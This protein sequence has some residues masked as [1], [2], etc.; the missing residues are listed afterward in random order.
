MWDP[1]IVYH[2]GRYFLFAMYTSEAGGDFDS[3]W[4][5]VSDDGV[6]WEDVGA[7]I[8]GQPFYVAKMFVRKLG[9]RFV[10]NHGS[11][12]GEPGY[13]DT[14]YFWESDDLITWRLFDENRALHPDPRWYR[15]EGRWD[16]MY[17][18]PD[19]ISGGYLGYC[20]GNP[21]AGIPYASCGL[22]QSDDGTHWQI[23][24]P[25]V[26]EW[27]EMLTPPWFEVGGC[28]REGGRYY[29]IGGTEIYGDRPGYT[30]NTLV[31]DHWNGPFRPD[32]EAYR[33][34]A[35]TGYSDINA[36]QWLASFARGV[37]DELLITN[38]VTDNFEDV[39]ELDTSRDGAVWFV[40]IK[41]AIIDDGHLRM[42]YWTGNEVL[43]G[44]RVEFGAVAPIHPT[45][46]EPLFGHEGDTVWVDS[47]VEGLENAIRTDEHAIVVMEAPLDLDRG[48]VIEGSI[49]IDAPFKF[50]PTRAGF[51]F[52]QEESTGTYLLLEAGSPRWRATDIGLVE[53]GPSSPRF[54][55]RDTTSYGAAT[56]TGI[57]DKQPHRFRILYRRNMFELYIDDLLMQTF[58]TTG[59]P[60][61]RIGFIVQNARCTF[62]DLKIWQM[63]L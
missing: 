23:L 55:V 24:P 54:D 28:E 62:D 50:R 13:Q 29:L 3:M 18:I 32:V 27:G 44:D 52:E 58:I 45:T 16:H 7:V 59:V 10:M 57:T 34:C 1:S 41:K 46:P 47:A 56:V 43:K 5:A 35:Q 51:Y 60:T 11:G 63:S 31:S 20:V 8:T 17:M 33:L 37:D 21:H 39:F 40:P 22:L 42:G 9:D 53:L 48:V 30:V 19:E 14:L 4:C 49:T 36:G 26:V 25:P 38:Y 12:S 61:G 2:D 15:P 6:H